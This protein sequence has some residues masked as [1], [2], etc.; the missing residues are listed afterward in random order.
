[1]TWMPWPRERDRRLRRL[2]LPTSLAL[3]QVHAATTLTCDAAPQLADSRA[4]SMACGTGEV[5]TQRHGAHL[6]SIGFR[7]WLRPARRCLTP[8]TVTVGITTASRLKVMTW[9][10]AGRRAGATASSWARPCRGT[11]PIA[12]SR[13]C[14]SGA[15]SACF[16][17]CTT[18]GRRARPANEGDKPDDHARHDRGHHAVPLRAS[19]SA[20]P[21]PPGRRA[22]PRQDAH[23][24]SSHFHLSVP[25]SCGAPVGGVAAVRPRRRQHQRGPSIPAESGAEIPAQHTPDVMTTSF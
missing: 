19:G 23:P 1:M 22:Q 10:T 21:A 8:E 16:T 3:G 20:L 9:S 17:R 7:R 4:R 13:R 6:G 2:P 11:Q 18:S 25:P 15:E 14:W 12:R 5:R 24:A